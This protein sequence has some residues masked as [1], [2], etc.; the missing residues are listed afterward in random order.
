M[1]WIVEKKNKFS[2]NHFHNKFILISMPKCGGY[3]LEKLFQQNGY[4]LSR[5]KGLNLTGHLTFVDTYLRIKDSQFSDIKNYLIPIRE[6]TSWRKS[7][8]QYV[9]HQPQDSGMYFLS[10]IFKKITFEEYID[11]L[12]NYKFKDFKTIDNLALLPRGTY[13]SNQIM[14]DNYIENVNI[15]IYDMTSGYSQLFRNYF[16][17]KIPEEIK[18]NKSKTQ[19]DISLDNNLSNSILKYDNIDFIKDLPYILLN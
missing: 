19:E 15:Y 11:N 7:F 9:K 5:P 13:L 14:K 12:I 6:A 17:I 4:N 3:S 18:E 16:S 8:Y 10:E 1:S 2:S